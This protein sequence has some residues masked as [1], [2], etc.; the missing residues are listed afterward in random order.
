MKNVPGMYYMERINL[1]SSL[2]IFETIFPKFLA[3]KNS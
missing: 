1:K 3:F 2:N